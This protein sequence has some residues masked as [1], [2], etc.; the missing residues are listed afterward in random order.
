[1][2]SLGLGADE[3][4]LNEA[5]VLAKDAGKPASSDVSV[6]GVKNFTERYRNKKVRATWG[7]GR[8]ADGRVLLQGRQKFFYPNGKLMWTATFDAGKKL[9]EERYLRANGTPVW[10]KTYAKDGSWTWQS[11]D[12]GGKRVAESKWQGKTLQSSDVPEPPAA[13]TPAA[14]AEAK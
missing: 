7:A 8:A 11:F 1:M 2:H 4:E 10:V 13:Q 5:W 3:I 9:G 6:T 14:K 12:R